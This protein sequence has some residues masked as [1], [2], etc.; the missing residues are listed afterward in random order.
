[1]RRISFGDRTFIP[2]GKPVSIGL[3]RRFGDVEEYGPARTITIVVGQNKGK[4]PKNQAGKC[5]RKPTKFSTALVDEAFVRARQAQIG[6][7]VAATRVSGRGWFR[8]KPEPSVTYEVSY[9]P[10]AGGG[11]SEERTFESFQKNMD[12]I[13]E[14]LAETF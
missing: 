7:Q 1:M 14:S 6:K 9:V 3:K 10:P 8:N 2:T 4:E 12:R 13:A 11:P 5:L